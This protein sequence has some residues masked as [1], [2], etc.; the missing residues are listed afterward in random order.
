MH[1]SKT[2]ASYIHVHIFNVQIAPM[3]PERNLFLMSTLFLNQV[4]NV[5]AGIQKSAAICFFDFVPF[6]ISMM[7]SYF[8]SVV[9][10]ISK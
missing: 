5:E 9:C 2:E 4:D 1:Y 8:E 10:L 7:A 6:S 3:C